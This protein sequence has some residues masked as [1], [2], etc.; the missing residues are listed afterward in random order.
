MLAWIFH[1]PRRF[2]EAYAEACREIARRK[3]DYPNGGMCHTC[4]DDTQPDEPICGW[5]KMK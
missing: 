2:F 5:C 4:G 3:R 1:A